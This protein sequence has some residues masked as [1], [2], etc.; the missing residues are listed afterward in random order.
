[1]TAGDVEVNLNNPLTRRCASFDGVDDRIA[2]FP[3][4]VGFI[5]ILLQRVQQLGEFLEEGDSHF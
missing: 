4:L 5:V 2:S 3:Y 1:M